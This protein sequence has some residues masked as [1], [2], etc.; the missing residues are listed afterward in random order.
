MVNDSHLFK[1][2]HKKIPGSGRKKGVE[3]KA[4]QELT[5][6]LAEL[7]CDPFEFLAR[8]VEDELYK[9][10]GEKID[11]TLKQRITCA[12]DL[13]K[14]ILPQ[15]KAVDVSG[16]VTVDQT[17]AEALAAASMAAALNKPTGKGKSAPLN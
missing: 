5:A 7:N 1:K 4:R 10:D 15:K 8:V 3:P 6:M 17:P 13:G 2:G 9:E 12:I 14:Y 11:V 16:H